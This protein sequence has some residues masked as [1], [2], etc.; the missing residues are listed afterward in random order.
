MSA[1]V[2]LS[3]KAKAVAK[4]GGVGFQVVTEILLLPAEGWVAL[5]VDRD[6][7]RQEMADVFK[8]LLL[9]RIPGMA[10][11]KGYDLHDL[12]IGVQVV[13]M[14]D[15]DEVDDFRRGWNLKNWK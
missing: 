5:D 15:P 10:E 2:E 14:D 7:L 12:Q 1:E 3:D 11:E 4:P 6:G 9:D 13:L 8:E